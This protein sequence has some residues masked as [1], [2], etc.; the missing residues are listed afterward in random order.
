ME[1]KGTYELFDRLVKENRA[2]IERMCARRAGG[3]AER[4]AEL[5][6]DCLIAVW[7]RLPSLRPGALR[8]Q[9]AAWVAWQCR[10]VFSRMRFDRG[11]WV[12]ID[13]KIAESLAV[14]P[15]D[16]P[17]EVIDLLASGLT[18]HERRMLDLMLEGRDASEV[19]KAM[20]IK[21]RSAVILR[22][23]VIK[24]MKDNIDKIDL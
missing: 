4:A 6:Q 16:N 11:L 15:E 21:Q 8:L 18:D 10:S 23:R 9:E 5:R 22:H 7:H 17:R 12:P 14:S 1:E 19:A 3:D 2:M 20:G 13:D 24:K